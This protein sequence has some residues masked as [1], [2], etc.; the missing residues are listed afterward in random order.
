MTQKQQFKAKQNVMKIKMKRKQK[1]N[2][3][4]KTKANNLQ[5]SLLHFNS[6][7]KIIYIHI[8]LNLIQRKNKNNYKC[9][10]R[11]NYYYLTNKQTNKHAYACKHRN[12][13]IYVCTCILLIGRI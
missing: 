4:N 13:Y 2:K 8:Y 1:K 7:K 12:M 3:Q 9:D 10:A 5:T 11:N 6:K